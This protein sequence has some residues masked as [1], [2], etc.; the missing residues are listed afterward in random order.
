MRQS[1]R[2]APRLLIPGVLT[3]L[4]LG[5]IACASAPAPSI[6]ATAQPE[7]AREAAP[8]QALYT[9]EERAALPG[10]AL[11]IVDMQVG[12]MPVL[13]ADAVFAGI[14]HLVEAAG[15]AGAPVMWV[16]TEDFGMGRDSPAFALSPPLVATEG[17]FSA[18]KSSG[19]NALNG[20][21]IVPLFDRAGIGTLVLCGINSDCCM[22]DT[23]AGALALGYRVI[24]A[25][26]GHSIAVGSG[27]TEVVERMNAIWRNTG[28]VRVMPAAEVIFPPSSAGTASAEEE[29]SETGQRTDS[30]P[31]QALYTPEERA[32]LP[33]VALLIIDMQVGM[34]PVRRSEA[35]FAGILRL[36][37]QAE[38]A[39]APIAWGYMD[40]F[41]MGRGSPG[42]E[43][44][45]PLLVKR[46]HIGF[47]KT[48]SDSFNGTGLA[49]IFDRA[50]VGTVVICGMSSDGCVKET[51]KGALKLG[52][53]VIVPEDTHTVAPDGG[54][55]SLLARM[56]EIWRAT[57]GVR[58]MPSSAVSFVKE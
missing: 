38:K 53:S 2:P 54:S 58:V 52:Y 50:G 5:F 23:V 34:M 21:G 44:A 25:Q 6:E 17:Q 8:L 42:Y 47:V 51:V 39:G 26:E 10:M 43:M 48:A 4:A 37:D 41:G 3:T 45:P 16:Y 57:P 46:S 28:G 13:R 15:R 32:A 29:V 9:P 49:A 31:L 24:V 14:L 12:R 18:I 20:T 19:G 35:V 55:E 27:S 30:A 36:V 1:I 33:G 7:S 22:K 11:V 40:E 56:E